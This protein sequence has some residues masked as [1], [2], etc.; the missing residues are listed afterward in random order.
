METTLFLS[1][2][3]GVLFLFLGTIL[4][5]R[6][7]S[8]KHIVS[9]AA[10]RPVTMMVVGSVE[11]AL[12]LLLALVHNSWSS[13][14]EVFVSLIGWLFLVEGLSYLII[15][16]GLIS[17]ILR[18]FNKDSWYVFCGVFIFLVG[19]YLFEVGFGLF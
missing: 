9:Q 15:P 12:G 11:F 6:K 4:M 16:E 14:P 10:R 18:R 13:V 2:Y 5:V 19:F 8:I 7:D 1:Q 17:R 3:F